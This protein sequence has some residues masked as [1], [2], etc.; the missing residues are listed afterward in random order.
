MKSLSLADAVKSTPQ[1]FEFKIKG[2]PSVDAT[3]ILDKLK[4]G[5]A[6]SRGVSP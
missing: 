5:K 1:E 3:E 4:S 6:S 2:K